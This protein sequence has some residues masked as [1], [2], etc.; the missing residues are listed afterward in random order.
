MLGQDEAVTRTVRCDSPAITDLYGLVDEGI[1]VLE[2][3]LE[4]IDDDAGAGLMVRV[5]LD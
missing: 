4:E 5:E 1:A 2:R 3:V